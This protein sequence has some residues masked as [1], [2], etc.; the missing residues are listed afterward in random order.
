[1]KHAV[2]AIILDYH[3][4]PRKFLMQHHM[5]KTRPWRFAGGRVEDREPKG[6]AIAREVREE[7]GILLTNYYYF[8]THELFVEE[9][10]WAVEYFICDSWDGTIA[11]QEPTKHD[12]IRWMTIEDMFRAGADVEAT[13]ASAYLKLAQEEG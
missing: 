6:L 5:G 1:M 7:L 13:V 2:C 11:I 12:E 4:S 9:Q 8:T 10:W 3:T